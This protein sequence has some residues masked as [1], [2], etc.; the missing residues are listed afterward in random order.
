M[1]ELVDRYRSRVF[2]LCYRMLGQHQDAEDA[3]QETFIRV[4]RNL[5]RWDSTRDFEPWLLAIAGN[6][7]RTALATRQ[8]RPTMQRLDQPIEDDSPNLQAAQ[9]LEEEVHLAILRL[10]PE[11][12]QAFVLFHNHELGY[13][14]IAASMKCPVGTAKTWVYRA[15]QELIRRLLSRGVVRE[16]N[17]EVRRVRASTA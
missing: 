12:R 8:R 14:E 5:A 1:I 6:R 4:L 9:T 16:F 15:R 7:C 10:R 13:A 3:T 2:G 11:L 17:H